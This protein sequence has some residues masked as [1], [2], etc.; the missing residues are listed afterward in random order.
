M[1]VWLLC[2]L[3]AAAALCDLKRNAVVAVYAA[4]GAGGVGDN[5]AAWTRA[6][7]TW[8]SAPNPSLVVDYIVEPKDIANYYSDGCQL[9]TGFPSLLLWVQPGGSADNYSASLGPGGR[10]NI[11]DFA[12]SKNGHVMGTCAGFYYAAG[13]YWWFDDFYP[14]AWMPHW[15]PTVEGPLSPIAVYPNYAPVQLSD[16][17]TVI[18]WGGVRFATP[19]LSSNNSAPS[20]RPRAARPH[21][22]HRSPCWA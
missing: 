4:T 15:F 5:S 16:G 2:L 3:P 21:P 9:A 12:A 6:F 13:T 19:A 17:R 11:L 10:D 20:L 8:F 18:Y 14:E 7:F 22:R 1:R